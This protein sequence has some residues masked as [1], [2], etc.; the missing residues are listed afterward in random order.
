MVPPPPPMVIEPAPVKVKVKPPVAV[1]A[2]V[3]VRDGKEPTAA[4]RFCVPPYI[5]ADPVALWPMYVT[6]FCSAMVPV[7]VPVVPLF[8]VIVNGVGVEIVARFA[9]A[10]NV[11]LPMFAFVKVTGPENVM[12]DALSLPVAFVTVIVV[13]VAV[14]AWAAMHASEARAKTASVLVKKLA[15]LFVFI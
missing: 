15:I 5:D 14:A 3:P 12:P 11:P 6:K 2:I 1:T 9:L 8:R 7:S 13:F 4:D 10:L